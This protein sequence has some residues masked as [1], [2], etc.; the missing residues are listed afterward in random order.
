MLTKQE[1]MNEKFSQDNAYEYCQQPH[2]HLEKGPAIGWVASAH[3]RETVA[4]H[5]YE[6]FLLTVS[7]RILCVDKEVTESHQI[8]HSESGLG[9][10]EIVSKVMS[11]VEGEDT[12]SVHLIHSGDTM[13]FPIVVIFLVSQYWRRK[14]PF[15]WIQI[16]SVSKAVCV[17]SFWLGQWRKGVLP[18][19]GFAGFYLGNT[20]WGG[21]LDSWKGRWCCFGR[22]SKLSLKQN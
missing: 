4:N 19:Y 22:V 6:A 15:L 13:F 21:V 8:G 5:R 2:E 18:M 3:K 20:G 17:S 11:H 12:S 16:N 14:L 9:V 7:H 1:H 10:L